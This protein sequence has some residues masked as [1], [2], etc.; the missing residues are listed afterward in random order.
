MSH[1]QIGAKSSTKIR[2]C[3]H[4]QVDDAGIEQTIDAAKAVV[5]AVTAT[6]GAK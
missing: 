4:Y 6:A 2:A 1:A 5:A 3:V